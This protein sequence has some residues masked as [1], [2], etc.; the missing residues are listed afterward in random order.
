MQQLDAADDAGV[1]GIEE[2]RLLGFVQQMGIVAFSRDA[3]VPRPQEIAGPK[4]KHAAGGP[5]H[6]WGTGVD[7]MLLRRSQ[8]RGRATRVTA[9]RGKARQ[10]GRCCRAVE[11]HREGDP[12]PARVAEQIAV[13]VSTRGYASESR[14]SGCV[15]S[16][17]RRRR[18]RA[19]E[20]A[21]SSTKTTEKLA[22]FVVAEARRASTLVGDVHRRHRVRATAVI[23]ALGVTNDGRR[24]RSVCGAAR[25][26]TDGRDQ[27]AHAESRLAWPSCRALRCCSRSTAARRSGRRSTTSSGI[28]AMVQRCQ[29][30]KA[31][32]CRDRFPRSAARYV[33]KQMRRRL[34]RGDARRP[35]RRSSCSSLV[36]RAPTEKTRAAASLR[37]GLDG[38]SRSCA[39]TSPATLWRTFATTNPIEKSTSRVRHAQRNVKRWQGR[40]RD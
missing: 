33:A 2:G 20:S 38:R 28:A 40:E 10:R 30:H 7:G 11:A 18:A 25:R 37:E 1:G 39:W 31:A 12:M 19:T 35:P 23:I 36:A 13:G 27:R 3:G 24:C 32:T 21:C 26:R 9:A 5:I 4:G 34:R 14:A 15:S 29:V 22:E 8:R 6:R 16:Q 17:A